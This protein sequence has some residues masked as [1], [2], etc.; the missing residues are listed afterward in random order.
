LFW[1]LCVW[2]IHCEV[3]MKLLLSRVASE[4]IPKPF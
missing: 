2:F 4:S 1:V 3:I